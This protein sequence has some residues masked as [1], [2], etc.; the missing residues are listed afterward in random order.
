MVRY[1]RDDRRSLGDLENMRIRTPNG[2]EVPFSQVALVEPGRGFASIERVDR[3]RTVNVTA[4][5][6]PAI[7]SVSAVVADLRTRILPEVL[8]GHPGVFYTFEGAQAEQADAAGGLQR[9]FILALLTIFALLAV[10]L[11]SYAQPLIIMAA[12]PFGLVG[13][14]WG[15][16]VMGLDMTVMSMFGLVALTGVVV[17]DSLVMVDFINRARAVHADLG[18][19]IRAAG[20]HQTDRREFESS[21]LRLAIREAGGNRFRPILL[22][23]LTTFLGLAPLMLERSIQAAFLVPMA[24][25][26][27][28]G[29]LFATF[30]TLILVPVSYLILDDVQRTLRR[31]FGPGAE[32]VLPASREGVRVVIDRGAAAAARVAEASS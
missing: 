22:T 28:F 7:T 18:R 12:I 32:T 25:S 16:V 21:G 17:N 9:G 8:A 24:V 1:P 31:A 5:V 20:G 26:L 27:A 30:I 11:R 2:G 3:N 29:V 23:S 6:D 13:A 19:R 15:H 4:S 10:P 14:V